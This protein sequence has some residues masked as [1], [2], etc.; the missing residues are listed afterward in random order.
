MAVDR[1]KPKSPEPAPWLPVLL[2]C[3]VMGTFLSCLQNG[4]VNLDDPSYASQNPHVEVG[5]T[6][7]SIR[8]AWSNT[9]SSNWHPLTW[10]SHLL[11]GQLYGLNPKGHHATSVLLHAANT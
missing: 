2:I 9:E 11:D 4:F 1:R 6:W 10:M 3:L 5:L 8:W 7:E